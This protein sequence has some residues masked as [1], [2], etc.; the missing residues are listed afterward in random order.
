MSYDKSNI[1]LVIIGNS[2]GAP[3]P[4]ILVVLDSKSGSSTLIEL[5]SE[6][7]SCPNLC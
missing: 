1:V 7:T 5:S 4:F 3:P 2:R 6:S